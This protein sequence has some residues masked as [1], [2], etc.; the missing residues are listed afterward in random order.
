MTE[1]RPYQFTSNAS[2]TVI[3]GD[4]VR[5]AA[6]TFAREKFGEKAIILNMRQDCE[7][8]YYGANYEVTVGRRRGAVLGNLKVYKRTNE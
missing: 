7:V 1:Y 6:A 5:D 4:D 3:E 8:E 2:D